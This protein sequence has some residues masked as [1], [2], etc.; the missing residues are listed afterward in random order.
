MA[1]WFNIDTRQVETDETRSPSANTLG[2][3]DSYAD[4]SQAL[5]HARENNE[6]WDAEDKAWNERAA[7]QGRDDEDLED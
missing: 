2:P 4:A 1:Y 7:T 5:E 6:R 3:Y